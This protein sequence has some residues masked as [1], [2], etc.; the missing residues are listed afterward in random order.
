MTWKCFLEED[1]C[2]ISVFTKHLAGNVQCL[3]LFALKKTQFTFL[4]DTVRIL[5]YYIEG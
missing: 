5:G 2:A 1:F 4:K 3:L